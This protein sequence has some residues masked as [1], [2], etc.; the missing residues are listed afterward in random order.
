MRGHMRR[1][2]GIPWLRVVLAGAL[3]AG[4][5]SAVLPVEARD[6]E[7]AN[8]LFLVAQ[9]AVDDGFYDVAAR[10]VEQYLFK[11]PQGEHVVQAKLLLGQCYFFRSQ[12]LKAYNVFQD[13]LSYKEFKDAT[14]FWLGETYFKGAD[15]LQAAKYYRQLLDDF[16]DSEFVPQAEYSLAWTF[17]EQGQYEKAQAAFAHMVK[18]FP[19]HPLVEDALFKLAQCAHNLGQYAP[20][21]DLF[22]RYTHKYPQSARLAEAFFFLA[23]AY[24]Y[25]EDYLT[26]MTYY[27]KAADISTEANVVYLARVSLGWCYLK[28]DKLEL[29]KRNFLDAETY[30]RQHDTLTDDVYLGLA[31]LDVAREEYDEALTAYQTILDDFPQSPKIPEAQLGRANIYYA[32]QDYPAAIREYQAVITSQEERLAGEGDGSFTE[33]AYYGLAWTYLKSGNPDRAIKTFQEIMNKS[34]SRIVKVSALTQIGNA[35]FDIDQLQKAIE[36][37]DRVLKD[38]PDSVY[39]DYVQFRQGVALLKLDRLDAATLSFQSLQNNFPK[40]PYLGDVPYYLGIAYFKKNDWSQAVTNLNAYLKNGA[41]TREFAEESRFIVGLALFNLSDYAGAMQ[42]FQQIQQDPA[43]DKAT[44]MNAELNI[45]KCLYRLGRVGEA[46]KGF[47]AVIERFPSEEPALDALIWLGDHYLEGKDYPSAVRYYEK[48]LADFPGTDKT[49]LL[50]F[51]LG[52]TFLALEQF[53]QALGYFKKIGPDAGEEI[54]GKARLA[55]ADIFSRDMP[56]DQALAAYQRI[57]ESFPDFRCDAYIKIGDIYKGEGLERKAIAALETARDAN[58]ALCELSAAEIQFRIAD[59]YEQSNQPKRAVEEY[60][61]I[62]YLYQQQ[63]DWVIKAYLRV[64][65]I[66]EDAEDWEEARRIYQKILT[67]SVDEAKYAVERIR[68]IE[69]NAL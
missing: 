53:D 44:R 55:I 4:A 69:E 2:K 15:Y 52:Q 26:A 25:T 68:W 29:A 10:Y 54:N 30:G 11:Y 47:G 23:E 36:V 57:A 40:S 7:P 27:A 58:Q 5:M 33:K 31:T 32:R 59:L 46:V 64:G 1:G 8:E 16:P 39:A 56:S 67:Y 34:S 63:T 13:L 49:G 65:R 17:F 35:Y 48:A 28:I 51:E 41:G 12:Y 45:A 60:L 19:A 24:Y 20:A 3:C 14:L 18:D 37:Y 66:F 21:I 9:K 61:K 50:Y 42:T 62:V 22:T 6:S 43:T 38:Y